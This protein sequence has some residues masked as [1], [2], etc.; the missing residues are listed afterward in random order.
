MKKLSTKA[1]VG[2]STGVTLAG[3]AGI[4]WGIFGGRKKGMSEED[5]EIA[6]ADAVEINDPEADPE[7][8]TE[9]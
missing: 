3:I 7:A 4:L 9:E 5:Y 1:K 8:D 6:D 2:I